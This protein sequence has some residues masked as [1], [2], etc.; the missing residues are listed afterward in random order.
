M[1]ETA[2]SRGGFSR[3]QAIAFE[4]GLLGSREKLAGDAG[5]AAA[6]YHGGVVTL[7]ALD[8]AGADLV[9]DALFGTGLTRDLE[10]DVAACV[11]GVAHSGVP[12]LA[13]DIPSGIDGDSGAICG[14]ALPATRKRHA[15]PRASLDI[16]LLPGRL[17]CAAR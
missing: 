7:E 2:S 17:I 9:I 16:W 11:T 14:V 3:R 5:A 12:V 13:V 15:S 6:R 4:L 10:G 8:P 1:A